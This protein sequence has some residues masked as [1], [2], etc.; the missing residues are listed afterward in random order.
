MI[1]KETYDIKCNQHQ[2]V[3]IPMDGVRPAKAKTGGQPSFVEK[4]QRM[5]RK[6]WGPESKN[7]WQE[8]WSDFMG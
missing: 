6:G 7:R 4:G 3:K 1:T 5:T 8:K 2:I